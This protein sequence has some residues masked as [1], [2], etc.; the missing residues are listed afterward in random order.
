[1][2]APP[3][4]KGI[5]HVTAV[6]AEASGNHD[7]YTRVLGM[8]LV[9][10]TVNQDD[11]SAYHLFYADGVGSPGSDLTFFD[12][13]IALEA[14]GTDAVTRTSL[15][16]AG[17]D[18]LAF[19]ADRLGAHGA[20]PS[21]ARRLDDR[22]IIDF[23][24]PEGQ[25]L[26]FV[27][28]SSGQTS[29]FDASPIATAH[30]IR[31]L[32]PPELS[33]ADPAATIPFLE[34][35]LGLAERRCFTEAGETIHV[36][37]A[38]GG[39]GTAA[40]LHLRHRPGAVT[41]PGA[42]GVHHIAFRIADDAYDGW[43]EHYRALGVRSSGPVDRFYFRSLY[44]REPNGI[45]IEIA[46]DGPGFHADEPIAT[47]GQR[48]SLPPILEAQRAQIEGKLRKIEAPPQTPPK[49]APLATIT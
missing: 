27:E 24:D 14:R 15:R 39:T 6:T 48:L 4:L 3:A 18:T 17:P 5:H 29:P 21:P 42:G 49:A 31:G 46:T 41:R 33:V 32:G 13:P 16:V 44:A 43:I 23:E 2:T 28:D 8:R 10:K 45:L 11:T 26:R 47:L 12:W 25:R 37:A 22:T 19:W 9:K 34:R 7:F 40:E 20:H 35:V 1:M 36:F 30:Q 38:E